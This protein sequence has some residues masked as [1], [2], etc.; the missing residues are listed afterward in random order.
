MGD[1]KNNENTENHPLD[2]HRR[3]SQEIS[4][5]TQPEGELKPVYVTHQEAQCFHTRIKDAI[6]DAGMYLQCSQNTAKAN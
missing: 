6:Q 3:K 5:K 1:F 4:M 2:T